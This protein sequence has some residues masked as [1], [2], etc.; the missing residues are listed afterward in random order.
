MHQSPGIAKEFNLGSDGVD[1]ILLLNPYTGKGVTHSI[2]PSTQILYP[3]QQIMI[4]NP[5]MQL[6]TP[7]L[8]SPDLPAGAK[9]NYY[10]RVGDTLPMIAAKFNSTVDAIAM[11]NNLT[12]I[13]AI[14]V[15]QKLI[16]PVN[17]VTATATR[18]PTVTSIP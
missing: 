16:I 10:V 12:D 8:I 2:D 11:E 9:V 17:L 14:Y 15:G 3:G 1:L 13:G 5:G 18:P 4:P 7:T 6:P